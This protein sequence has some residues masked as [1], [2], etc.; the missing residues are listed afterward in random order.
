M[1]AV[2]LHGQGDVRLHEEPD[3]IAAEGES[4]VR[5]HAVGLCGSDL[6]WYGEGGIGDSQ[7]THPVVPGHEFYGTA[8]IGAYAGQRVVVDPAIPCYHCEYCLR[9]DHNL[10]SNLIFAGHGTRDGGMQDLLSWPDTSLTPLPATISDTE[11][12]VLEPLG[13][14]IHAFDLSHIKPGM[15]VGVVGIGPIGAFILQLA[16]NA[17]AAGIVAVEPLAHRRELAETLGADLVI[18]PGQV[19]GESDTCDLVFEVNG[20]PAAVAESITLAKPGARIVLVG[21]PDEDET[22]F[23]ASKARR[24]AITFVCVRRMKEVYGRAIA[25]MERDYI[26][27]ESLVS[28]VFAPEDVDQAFKTGAARDGHKV[29][30]KFSDSAH[31]ENLGD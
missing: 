25:L 29:V 11:A 21:I 5:I 26:D 12:V 17:N 27:G 2:R 15:K 18:E 22:T 16:R 24:K 4:L 1:R 28:H 3:T 7:I 31:G 19:D 10:C 23:A 9:G 14:A 20:N 8:L 30:V 13:V 6:H